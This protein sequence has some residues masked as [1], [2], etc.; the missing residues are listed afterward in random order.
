MGTAFLYGNGG[1][2][3]TGAALTVNA[4]AGATV[5]IS[6]DGKTKTKV[7]DS[8]GVAVFKGLESGTW[9]LSIYDDTHDPTTPI[10]F[11]VVANYE[12]TVQF[13][14]YLYNEGDECTSITGGFSARG[15]KYGPSYYSA[16]TPSI[17][18]NNDSMTI[19]QN[20]STHYASG[21]V[22]TIKD[23]DLS[24][25]SN[26]YIDFSSSGTGYIVNLMVMNRG[27]TYSGDAVAALELY[28]MVGSVPLERVVK[29]MNISGL[30]GSYDIVISLYSAWASGIDC[31]MNLYRLYLT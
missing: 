21:I 16:V 3:G 26:L 11:D 27:Q 25:F 23:I 10:P 14:Q 30:S 7:V 9:M 1:S 18:R 6:K 15:L 12:T 20:T 22:E 2:G 13:M 28:L 8:S 19:K 31:T 29:M 4:P 5:T 24:N 17:T